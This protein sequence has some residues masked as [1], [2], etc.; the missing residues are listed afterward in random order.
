MN[1]LSVR[2]TNLIHTDPRPMPRAMSSLSGLNTRMVSAELLKLRRRRGLVA[3]SAIFTI[4]VVVLVFGVMAILH[5]E[6]PGKYAPAG[7]VSNLATA[8]G[9]L[10]TFGSVAAI[11]LGA[12][13]GA[14]D[15]QA[16]VFRDLV[17][18]GRSRLAL[19]AARIPGGLALL[20]PLVVAAWVI[21]C[22]AA[23]VLA[24]SLPAPTIG[25]M[26]A[27]SAW[28]VLATTSN[29][30][31][32]LAVASLT[33]SRSAAVGQV[34]AW[35]FIVSQLLVQITALGA[36]RQLIQMEALTRLM[37]AAL[38]QGSGDP[39]IPA[40]SVG[41]AILVVVAWAVVPL[42]LAARRTATRDA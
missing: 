33:G 21:S 20:W 1:E 2:E 28:V 29:F 42:A 11:L 18:T 39:V 12:T 27:G 13:A 30:L 36:W 19:F 40:M 9:L 15:T 41:V 32:A 10:A 34:F 7:G 25:V 4:G 38:R 16:G 6:N 3:W 17:S 8:M 31:L 23:V 22:L 26:L 5:A 24:G 37:P 35:Q 14:G